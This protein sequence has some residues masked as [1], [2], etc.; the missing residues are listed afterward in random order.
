[1]FFCTIILVYQFKVLLVLWIRIIHQDKTIKQRYR[2]IS[3]E[4]NDDFHSEMVD[5]FSFLVVPI[6]LS[7][8]HFFQK[9]CFKVVSVRCSSAFDAIELQK[10]QP[11]LQTSLKTD[12]CH[13]SNRDSTPPLNLLVVSS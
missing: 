1:M 6:D 8:G 2:H 11:S 9:A 7:S 5:I 4:V 3:D 13:F 10:Y 12:P